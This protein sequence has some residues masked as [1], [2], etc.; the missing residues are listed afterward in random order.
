MNR[1]EFTLCS[2]G[3]SMHELVSRSGYGQ[4]AAVLAPGQAASPSMDRFALVDPELLP[5]VKGQP[6]TTMTEADIE[7]SRKQTP[8][9]DG[10]FPEIPGVHFSRRSI[11]GPA[12]APDVRIVIADTAPEQ[13]GKPVLLHLHGG[14]Y[15]VGAP[16]AFVPGVLRY[17]KP[18]ECV[19]VSVDYRLAPE[20]KFPG[21]LNDNYAALLWVYR[22]AD[23]LGIDRKRIAICGESA[24]GGHAAALAIHARDRNEVPVLFQL[25]I[26]PMLDDRTGSTRA[27]PP[28]IGQIGWGAGS[29][30]FGW[31]SL[32]GVPAGSAKVPYGASPARVENLTGLPPAFIGVGA[33]DLFVDED[34]E[35][36]RRLIDAG[37][38]TELLVVPGAYHA[39]DL[40]VPDA[41]V[42]KAFVASITAA[43]QRAFNRPGTAK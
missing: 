8:P 20:T 18:S 33:I 25:L 29:N 15:V 41:R 35:Y 11:P 23:E 26:Y 21:S 24:G 28:P 39:F 4:S 13:K 7:N 37:V 5:A 43:L 2:L 1:R 10:A 6:L 32:L 31:T 42:S 16:M 38:S 27:V 19:V 34:L 22:N 36:A 17:A 30:R 3:F 12:G 40:M 9:F 14:G